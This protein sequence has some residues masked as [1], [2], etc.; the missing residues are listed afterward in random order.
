MINP[1]P[2]GLD[3]PPAPD[4]RRSMSPALASRN[5]MARR[6]AARLRSRWRREGLDLQG[7][8]ERHP[9]ASRHPRQEFLDR[10][11]EVVG[12]FMHGPAGLVDI[13]LKDEEQRPVYRRSVGEKEFDPR[14]GHG[15]R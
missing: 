10:C 9:F 7:G 13:E 4:R 3:V 14:L 1:L 12:R 5:T 2:Q 8:N 15:W 11:L 6:S